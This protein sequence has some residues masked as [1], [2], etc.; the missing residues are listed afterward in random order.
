MINILTVSKDTEQL[1]QMAAAIR[2]WGYQV[3]QSEDSDTALALLG[4]Q[5][6]Q[7]IVADYEAG[8]C[9][10]TA[11]LR[12]A[13]DATPV[14]ILIP[15][16]SMWDKRRVFRSGA[17]GYMP[18]PIDM[19]ELQMRIENLLWRCNIVSA[20]VLKIGSCE[21]HSGTLQLVTPEETIDLRRMEFLLLQKLLSY[22]GRIFTRPQLMDE[23]WGYD[24]ES[25]PRTVDTHVKL[26]RRKL[27]N[28]E[29]IRIQTVRGLGYRVAIPKKKN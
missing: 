6:V 21:L 15:N 14:I 10:L 11:E 12:Q 20:A 23:L 9:E 28:V 25:E 24:S 19:E 8:G 26:L 17:D 16:N 27:K 18:L 7:L 1:R 13:E 4:R 3:F 22:P 5:A 2:R 29:D